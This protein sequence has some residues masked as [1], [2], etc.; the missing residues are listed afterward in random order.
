MSV[1]LSPELEEAIQRK[2]AG[3]LYES[4]H[5]VIQEAL[6]LLDDRD[7]LRALKLEELRAEIAI[8]ID[9]AERGQ[10]APFDLDAIRAKVA[11]RSL[12]SD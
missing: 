8:G 1:S 4:T 3:G 7:R 6:R 9:Q 5:E 12:W 11:S 2:V 10:V